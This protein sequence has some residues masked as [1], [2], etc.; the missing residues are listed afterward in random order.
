MKAVG[1]FPFGPYPDPFLKSDDLAVLLWHGQFFPPS[2]VMMRREVALSAGGFREG[3]INGE[4]LDMWFR[5]ME[6]GEIIGVPE[7]LTV[8]GFTR[9]RSPVTMSV[10]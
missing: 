7:Q 3:L 2:S 9:G 8:I 6:W 10:K 5:L 4:D 1:F